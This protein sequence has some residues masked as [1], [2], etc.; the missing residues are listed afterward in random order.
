MRHKLSYMAIFFRP[1]TKWVIVEHPRFGIVRGLATTEAIA[2]DTE[3]LVNYHINLG[4][5]PEWYKKVWVRHQREFKKMSDESIER[6][7]WRWVSLYFLNQSAPF[8]SRA[9]LG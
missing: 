6:L 5:A 8:I 3:I 2:K 4:D 7:M 1:N 9:F